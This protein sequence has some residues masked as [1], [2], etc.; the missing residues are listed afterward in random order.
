MAKGRREAR[1]RRGWFEL[2]P[3]GC[4]F[5][6]GRCCCLGACGSGQEALSRAV[7]LSDVPRAPAPWPVAIHSRSQAACHPRRPLPLLR[8]DAPRMQ[9]RELPPSGTTD[10]DRCRALLDSFGASGGASTRHY[11]CCRPC[12]GCTTISTRRL[13]ARPSA[14]LLLATGR[15]NP[16]PCA[17][18]RCSGTP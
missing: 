11:P 1:A 7:S 9:R 18:I 10:R 13:L 3:I 5:S 8:F 4:R 16:R 6:K 15:A 2:T 12:V 17:W 14:V